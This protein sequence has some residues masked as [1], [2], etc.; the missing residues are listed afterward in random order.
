M[1]FVT[2]QARRLKKAS[3]KSYLFFLLMDLLRTC[4]CTSTGHHFHCCEAILNK[5]TSIWSFCDILYWKWKCL[6]CQCLLHVGA[7]NSMQSHCCS[8]VRTWRYWECKEDW[9][10]FRLRKWAKLLSQWNGITP[11]ALVGP[12]KKLKIRWLNP[13]KIILGISGLSL[14]YTVSSYWLTEIP[15]DIAQIN[16]TAQLLWKLWLY[17]TITIT[18]HGNSAWKLHIAE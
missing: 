4:S 12:W 5:W 8:V 3:F 18:I 13:K 1:L 10:I 14:Y 6:C 2:Y 15:V 7:R 16:G 17:L 9:K 11:R